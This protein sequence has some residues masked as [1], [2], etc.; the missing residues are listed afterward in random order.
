MDAVKTIG[1][2]PS[3]QLARLARTLP[4]DARTWLVADFSGQDDSDLPDSI[5]AALYLDGSK[6]SQATAIF[7]SGGPANIM[8]AQMK[9]LEI[10]EV[11][12]ISHADGNTI[13]VLG[14]VNADSL[15]KLI[16]AMKLKAMRQACAEN[17]LIISKAM[18]IYAS[19]NNG[20]YPS[21]LSDLVKGKYLLAKYLVSPASGRTLKTD[22]DG[23]PL[24]DGDYHYIYYDR[25]L[26][27]LD[28][29][30]CIR[31]YDAFELSQ[32]K[33]THVVQRQ[34]V[35]WLGPKQFQEALKDSLAKQAELLKKAK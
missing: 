8:M 25:D 11:F 32:G 27:G 4:T 22:K 16:V 23:L 21:T 5:I 30:L 2:G 3:D 1:S 20:R 17:L 15:V 13:R 31:V 29:Q 14:T 6:P 28:D 34:A 33:G 24:E 18:A 7:Q 12:D 35:G 9:R 19:D 10:T 26:D